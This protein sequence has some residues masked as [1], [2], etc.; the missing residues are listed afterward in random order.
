MKTSPLCILSAALVAALLLAASQAQAEVVKAVFYPDAARF[1]EQTRVELDTAGDGLSRAVLHLPD[2]A[3]PETLLLGP[4][5]GGATL[6]DLSWESVQQPESPEI[7]KLRATLEKLLQRKAALQGRREAAQARIQLWSSQQMYRLQDAKEAERLAGLVKRELP[8]LYELRAAKDAALEDLQQDIDR[9]R[10][11]L[12]QATGEKRRAWEVSLAVADAPASTLDLE[13]SYVA[14]NCGWRP[15]YRLEAKPRTGRVA[16]AFQADIR[17]GAG[18]DVRAEI[19]LATTR[20]SPSI[21]PPHLPDWIIRPRPKPSANRGAPKMADAMVA[22]ERAAMAEAPAEPKKLQQSTFALWRVGERSLPAGEQKRLTLRREAWPAEFSWLL[23]PSVTRDSYL[24]AAVELDEPRDLPRGDALFL[25]DGAMLATRPFA[26]TGAETT[27]FFGK[28]PS[29]TAELTTRRKQSG[30]EGFISSEQT[31]DWKWSIT[32]TNAK[33]YAAPVRVEEPR[34][35]AR[36]KKIELEITADP[37]PDKT[38]KPQE[39]NLLVWTFEAKPQSKAAIEYGVHLTAP[40][41][42]RLDMGR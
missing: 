10:K 42:M 34:P 37:K 17:Q 35:E 26:F 36:S 16:F 9:V 7:T 1:H 41:A 5:P 19:F 2:E 18:R 11:E 22:V 14:G 13:Y 40:E 30:S 25:V 3:R 6:A 21:R 12:E 39:K 27:L 23:R 28:D 4:L 38:E 15:F 33:T 20:P 8:G 29:V 31:F 24:R 32:V